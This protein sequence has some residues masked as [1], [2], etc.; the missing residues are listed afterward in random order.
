M[1]MNYEECEDILYEAQNAK[2]NFAYVNQFNHMIHV[3]YSRLTN[4][5]LNNKI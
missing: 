5:E 2:D 1:I 3:S 4:N